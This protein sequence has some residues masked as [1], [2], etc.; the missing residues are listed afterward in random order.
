MGSKSNATRA[1]M[2]TYEKTLHTYHFFL[3]Y[4]DLS[5]CELTCCELICKKEKRK[6]KI[7]SQVAH[8]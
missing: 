8:T 7:R 5:G 6:G 4:L 3:I 2:A 1:T